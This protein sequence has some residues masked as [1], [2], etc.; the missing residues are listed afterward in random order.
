MALHDASLQDA[1][2]A[3]EV[4]TNRQLYASV[5]ERVKEIGVSA[6]MP[7]SN[8]SIVDKAE[9]PGTGQVPG[10]CKV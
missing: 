3:R 9:V 7:T 8:V 10:S 6:D 1:V 4:D 2:L 5:L